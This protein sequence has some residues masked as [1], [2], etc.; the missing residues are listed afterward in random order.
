MKHILIFLSLLFPTLAFSQNAPSVTTLSASDIGPGDCSGVLTAG[1]TAQNAFIAARNRHG[2]QIYNIDTTEPLWISF[3][4]V[5]V[6]NAVGSF[7][8]AAAAATTF[9]GAGSYY[10][11]IGFNTNLSVV[12][13]TT[14]HKFT[15]SNW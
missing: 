1:G 14:G 13:A 2:F 7:P 12:A 15:C 3:T 11:N 6:P 9:A 8:L 10:S 5:A 4:G